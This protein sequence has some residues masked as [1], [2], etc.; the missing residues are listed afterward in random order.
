[1]PAQSIPLYGRTSAAPRWP[2]GLEADTRSWIA[3]WNTDPRPFIWT[4]TAEEIL[5]SLARFCRRIFGAAH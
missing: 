3:H 2:L 1:L 4:K 5:E